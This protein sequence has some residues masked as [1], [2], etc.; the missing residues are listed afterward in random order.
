MKKFTEFPSSIGTS[1]CVSLPSSANNRLSRILLNIN[2]TNISFHGI[3]DMSIL[4]MKTLWLNRTVNMTI[5]LLPGRDF[6]LNRIDKNFWTLSETRI[7]K[8]RIDINQFS[9][10][11]IFPESGRRFQRQRSKEFISSFVCLSFQKIIQEQVDEIDSLILNKVSGTQCYTL[12]M[13][14]WMQQLS[15]IRKHFLNDIEQT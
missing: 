6:K 12:D 15:N 5:L 7:E 11:Q 2:L 10:L 3:C 4:F 8:K 13:S 1:A 14:A 9:P